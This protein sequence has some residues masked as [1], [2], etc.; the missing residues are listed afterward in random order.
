MAQN[1]K[2]R[3]FK[4]ENTNKWN[5]ASVQAVSHLNLEGKQIYIFSGEKYYYRMDRF[6]NWVLNYTIIKSFAWER[7]GFL[8]LSV[9]LDGF[10][11]FKGW[12]HSWHTYGR[13]PGFLQP[14]S[15]KPVPSSCPHFSRRGCSRKWE[16]LLD[17]VY[18]ELLF[19]LVIGSYE[20][21]WHNCD[22]WDKEKSAVGRDASETGVFT[23]HQTSRKMLPFFSF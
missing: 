20:S 13:H 11:D 21:M 5:N 22:Q 1:H 4:S 23:F 18:H 15:Q 16:S 7:P 12:G 19:L 10:G 6:T 8:G 9:F 14:P 17:W 2:I 3:C